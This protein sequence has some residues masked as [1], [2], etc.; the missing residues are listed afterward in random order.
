MDVIIDCEN[1]PPTLRVPRINARHFDAET[2]LF[3]SN[4]PTLPEIIITPADVEGWLA[5]RR[6][7]TLARWV[8]GAIA[9]CLSV[10]AAALLL[11]A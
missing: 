2:E 8:A 6:R 1:E 9:V 11:A 4:A 10:L 5:D 7:R 3:L